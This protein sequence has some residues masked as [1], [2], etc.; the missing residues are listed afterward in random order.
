M[1]TCSDSENG[2]LSITTRNA[3]GE[4][5]LVLDNGME[6]VTETFDTSAPYVTTVPDPET[7]Y[8][9]TVTTAANHT[10]TGEI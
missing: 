10:Y 7:R 8:T 2:L 4:A 5:E 9:I 3:E 1:V 6:T